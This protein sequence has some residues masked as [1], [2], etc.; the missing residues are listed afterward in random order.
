VKRKRIHKGES[1]DQQSFNMV[2]TTN[3]FLQEAAE[4]AEH[5]TS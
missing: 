2:I 4:I 3:W 1:G 5:R